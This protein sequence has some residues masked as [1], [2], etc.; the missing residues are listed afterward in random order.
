ME[1]I[2]VQLN[3]KECNKVSSVKVNVFDEAEMEQTTQPITDRELNPELGIYD[4]DVLC[5]RC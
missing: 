5:L 2:E 1:Q 3:C 4:I